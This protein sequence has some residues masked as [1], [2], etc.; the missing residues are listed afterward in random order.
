MIKL[1][2]KPTVECDFE[3]KRDFEEECKELKKEIAKLKKK[4][5]NI[6]CNSEECPV[7]YLLQRAEVSNA[8]AEN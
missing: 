6:E 4:L 8:P 1:D 5:K 3:P 2:R 7:Y